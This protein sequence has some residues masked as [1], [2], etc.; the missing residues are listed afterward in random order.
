MVQRAREGDVPTIAAI[1]EGRAAQSETHGIAGARRSETNPK[2][3]WLQAC[4]EPLLN[5][6]PRLRE[7]PQSAIGAVHVQWAGEQFGVAVDCVAAIC[8]CGSRPGPASSSADSR[9]HR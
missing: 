3:A 9:A 6:S 1:D 4:S 7:R 2:H 8:A 5:L